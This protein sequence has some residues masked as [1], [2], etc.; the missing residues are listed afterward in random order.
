[1]SQ[2]RP[3]PRLVA[4]VTPVYNGERYLA[5][6]MD[7]VQASDYPRLIHIVLDN[8]STDATPEIISRYRNSRVPVTISRN[9]ATIP[10]IANFNAAVR[11]V[12]AEASYLRLLCADD[13]MAANA[14]S[15][16]VEVAERDPEIGMV[17]CLCR[18]ES[19]RGKGLSRNR[20]IFDGKEVIRSFLRHEHDALAGTEVL[21]RRSKLDG[22][23]L[24]YDPTFSGMT[25]TDANLRM[26][27]TSK[28]GFVHEELAMCRQ[29]EFSHSA[30]FFP[31]FYMLEWLMLLNRYGHFVLDE[32]EY[33]ARRSAYRRHYLRRL[34]LM[35]WRDGDKATFDEHMAVLRQNNDPVNWLD[36]TD[37]LSEWAIRNF[38]RSQDLLEST[39]RTIMR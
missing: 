31:K 7:C 39:R 21:I 23:H 13:M 19:L 33:R 22:Q 16:Q 9:K 34:L 1:M 10:M 17:G 32:K 8:A 24:Y 28:F 15:R 3:A 6:T 30:A 18:A 2:E 14:I 29:H 27:V 4:I 11:M 35:R 12:P 5:E 36:F 37:A 25:D 26:C 38:I 20:N